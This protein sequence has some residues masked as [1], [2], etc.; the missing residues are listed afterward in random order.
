[1]K[2]SQYGYDFSQD[3]IAQYPTTNRDDA[4]LMVLHRKSNRIEHKIFK[5]LTEYFG[6]GDLFVFNDTQIFPA[7]MHGNKEK[8]N[9]LI[10]VFLLRELQHEN[11]ICNPGLI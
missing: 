2:L 5:E 7:L 10:E 11:P 6:D 3:M 8:T 9:A 1:M 4:R